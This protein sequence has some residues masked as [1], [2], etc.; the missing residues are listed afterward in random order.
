[1]VT[2]LALLLVSMTS[3]YR[4]PTSNSYSYYDRREFWVSRPI[5]IVFHKK[6]KSWATQEFSFKKKWTSVLLELICERFLKTWKILLQVNGLIVTGVQGMQQGGDS[7]LLN[8]HDMLLVLE[9]TLDMFENMLVDTRVLILKNVF[10]W[11]FSGAWRP[12]SINSYE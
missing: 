11:M 10:S 6:C 8:L 9:K 1:M 5:T 2:T 4:R 7:M 3:S 12:V